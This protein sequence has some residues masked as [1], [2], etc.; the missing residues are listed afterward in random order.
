MSDKHKLFNSGLDNA[1]NRMIKFTKAKEV[2]EKKL[3]VY[4]KDAVKVNLSGKS[5]KANAVEKSERKIEIPG[6]LS[7]WFLK[8]KTA[9]IFFGE[10]SFTNKRE[11]ISP[12]PNKKKREKRGS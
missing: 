12:A 3:I 9:K 5:D 2:N 11:N 6:E 1:H 8:N 10:L 4:V 7:Q